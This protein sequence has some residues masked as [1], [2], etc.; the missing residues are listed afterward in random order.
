MNKEFSKGFS[1]GIIAPLFLLLFYVIFILDDNIDSALSSFNH[2][3]TMTH[4]ISLSVFFI[5]LL[6][7]FL[8]IN[9]Q[10]DEI[11]KGIIGATFIYT[12]IVIYIKFF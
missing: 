3:N 12:F 8:Y 2:T 1:I 10:K 4:H 6:F 5:N 9:K 7:F 11:A